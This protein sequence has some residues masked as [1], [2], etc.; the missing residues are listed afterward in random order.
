MN[1]IRTHGNSNYA[2]V[3]A[4]VAALSTD[5]PLSPQQKRYQ[6]V[7]TD[8]CAKFGVDNPFE[9]EDEQTKA[10]FFQEVQLEWAMQ[11]DK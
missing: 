7:F 11:K 6:K 8:T 3:A 5:K 4:Q 1:V 9:L 10:R 2:V